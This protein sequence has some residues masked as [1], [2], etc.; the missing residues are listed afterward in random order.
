VHPLDEL[1]DRWWDGPLVGRAAGGTGRWWNRLLPGLAYG[2]WL[3]FAVDPV[4]LTVFGLDVCPLR[5]LLTM[6]VVRHTQ[7]S[8]R[9]RS[10]MHMTAEVT[11]S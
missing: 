9:P 1:L 3:F 7:S 8:P 5:S 4:E 10:R 6:D 2:I 11:F